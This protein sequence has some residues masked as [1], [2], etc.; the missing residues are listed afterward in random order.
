MMKDRQLPADNVK[1][2]VYSFSNPPTL[3]H[4][5]MEHRECI[6]ISTTDPGCRTWSVMHWALLTLPIVVNG[7]WEKKKKP[8][9]LV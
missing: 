5:V 9:S 7:H 6:C 4:C 2:H 3:W 8:A 1:P